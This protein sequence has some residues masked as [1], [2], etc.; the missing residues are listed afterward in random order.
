MSNTGCLSESHASRISAGKIAFLSVLA[1]AAGWCGVAGRIAGFVN[2]PHGGRVAGAAVTLLNQQTNAVQTVRTD[3][4]GIY[5]FSDVAVGEYDI[6]ISAAGF[7][8]Y[9]RTGVK[10][11][12]NGALVEDFELA[13]GQRKD[14][15][16]VSALAARV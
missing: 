5:S 10:V 9:V 4:Q 13:V 8:P 1:A 6:R 2:D 11:D 12:A 14:V 7:E 16:T 3:S 15:V